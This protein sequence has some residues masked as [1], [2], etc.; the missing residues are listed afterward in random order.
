MQH[1]NAPN[2]SCIIGYTFYIATDWVPG[3]GYAWEDPT[4]L[5]PK[6]F[7]DCLVGRLDDQYRQNWVPKMEN[8]PRFKLFATL[9]EKRF[10]RSR[11][12]DEVKITDAR[13]TISRLRLDIHSLNT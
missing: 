8:S 11:Y 5:L 2:V 10:S 6:Q 4:S 12:L 3:L 9:K 13:V 7:G 1:L